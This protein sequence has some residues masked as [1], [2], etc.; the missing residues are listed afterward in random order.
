LRVEKRFRGRSTSPSPKSPSAH[1]R[2]KSTTLS[3]DEITSRTEK[4]L[5]QSTVHSPEPLDISLTSSTSS[6]RK[7]PLL[8]RDS[9]PYR[10]TS[11]QRDFSR[12]SSPY[13][14]LKKSPVDD[15]TRYSSPSKGADSLLS[16]RDV[17]PY[18]YPLSEPT[19]ESTHYKY[20][21]STSDSA[22]RDSSF[23]KPSSIL[24]EDD[25]F[26]H[27]ETSPSRYSLKSSNDS[28]KDKKLDLCRSESP[29]YVKPKDPTLKFKQL[30]EECY[31]PGE[32][33]TSP[34]L[35]KFKAFSSPTSPEI[36]FRPKIKYSEYVSPRKVDIN[37]KT[38]E[39]LW[40]VQD[41]EE[42]M[43]VIESK[44]K[45]E[46]KT[47]PL[48]RFKSFTSEG[49]S[50]QKRDYPIDYRVSEDWSKK[51]FSSHS[52]L[53]SDEPYRKTVKDSED[54]FIKR[55][56]RHSPTF[57]SPDWETSRDRILSPSNKDARPTYLETGYRS[58][59]P[60]PPRS[61]QKPKDVPLRLGMYSQ[62]K[63]S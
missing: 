29:P 6:L 1:R 9:P 21:S 8:E 28:L 5:R 54:E 7:S 46:I 43:T 51:S 38:V 27:R 40:N 20:V 57:P 48:R 47:S 42:I 55:Y 44:E 53:E 16:R 11:P 4:L 58:F 39:H 15:L 30:I 19:S 36:Q 32:E 35:R 50:Y 22:H 25:A 62:T 18:K 2:L 56:V 41:E 61:P 17:S 33:Q 49:S 52:L 13:K 3:F 26:L 37:T 59:N 45:Y 34:P 63:T 12:D 31:G 23:Y 24:A 10:Y 14:H 60:F